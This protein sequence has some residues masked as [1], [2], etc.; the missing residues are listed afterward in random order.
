MTR[1]LS[2]RNVAF[3]ALAC[4]TI[5]LTIGCS[6]GTGLPRTVPVT[7]KV[8]YKGVPVGGATVSFIG[9]GDLR[10]A[11]AITESDG[12]YSLHTLDA[13]GAMPGKYA[14]VVEKTE[15]PPE[16]TKE[17]SMEDA[18][19]MAGRPP[20]APKRLLP[21]KYGD[22]TKTPFRYEVKDGQPNQ[23]DLQLTD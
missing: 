17:V 20:P 23:F 9:E 8:T 16:L 5:C 15:L 7:G 13:D 18:A 3:A 21:I 2:S 11:V 22:A 4:H 10:P 12:S 14:V 6:G 1:P 19:K